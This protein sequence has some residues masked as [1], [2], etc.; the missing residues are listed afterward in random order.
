MRQLDIV[1][2]VEA[3]D[4]ITERLVVFLLNEEVVVRVVDGLDVEL[5]NTVSARHNRVK[6]GAYMLHGDQVR[7][8]ERDVVHLPE[9]TDNAGVVDA[10]NENGEEVG[11]EGGLFLEVEREGLVIAG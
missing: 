1:E 4:R 8:N 9:H 5:D 7:A 2:V 10:G 11:K 3:I 6:D